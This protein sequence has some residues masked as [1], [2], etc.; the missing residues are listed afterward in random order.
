VS[1]RE[2]APTDAQV[3]KFVYLSP[4]LDSALLEMREFSKKRQDGIVSETKIRLLNR[5]L[6]D[7]REIL[8]SEES[9]RY[10]DPLSKE[11]VPQNSD[12]VLILGQYRAA[13]DSFQARHQEAIDYNKTWITK[14]WIDAN[15]EDEDEDSG[16]A[17]SE[18]NGEN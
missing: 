17:E 10:L 8:R 2:S 12:A 6:N 16:D 18:E 9:F 15:E 4:M 13:M 14:E 1:D 3:E 7:I 5:L 11:Q